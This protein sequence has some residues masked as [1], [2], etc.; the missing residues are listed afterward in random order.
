[1]PLRCPHC[2]SDRLRRLIPWWEP[3]L[4][5]VLALTVVG[6][7]SALHLGQRPFRRGDRMQCDA[8]VCQFFA[9]LARAA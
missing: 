2:R 9:G 6:L 4:G 1:V 3:W 5:L 8:C 7:P